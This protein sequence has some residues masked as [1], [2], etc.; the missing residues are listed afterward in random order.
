MANGRPKALYEPVHGSAPDIAGQ[1]KAN[2]IACIL[3]FAMALR[4]SFDLGAEA[5]RLE[6]AVQK[7]LADGL[8]TADLMGPEGGS[9]VS[10]EAMGDAVVAALDA[11][12]N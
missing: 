3:S 2:P 7:V 10:T 9:P 1:G 11:S 6:G 5:D 4:Y 12:L 8:R